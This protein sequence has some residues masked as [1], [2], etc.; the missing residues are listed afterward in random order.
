MAVKLHKN[1]LKY[2]F[3][4]IFLWSDAALIVTPKPT[5]KMYISCYKVWSW[6]KFCAWDILHISNTF[7]GRCL[8]F[9]KAPEMSPDLWISD[10]SGTSV[11][12]MGCMGN[13]WSDVKNK[14]S[15]NCVGSL[16]GRPVE[17]LFCYDR[18]E[19]ITRYIR[20]WHMYHHPF[21]GIACVFF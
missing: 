6:V 19:E 1:P 13:I 17:R 4:K 2:I 14:N 8:S 12:S 16:Y 7:F 9:A 20:M 3:F 10:H 5:I 18:H 11:I 15:G 21:N